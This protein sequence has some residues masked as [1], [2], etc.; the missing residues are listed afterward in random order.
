MSDRPQS[1][2]FEAA[3]P[4][5]RPLDLAEFLPY[6]LSVLMNLISRGL[7]RLYGERFGLT[8]PEWR[9]M[10]ALGR[11]PDLSATEVAARS[12]MDKVQVSRAVGRLIRAGR[13]D[14][15]TASG[16]RRRSVLRLTAAGTAIYARIVPLARAYEQALFGELTTAE[17]RA[18]D[19]MLTDLT[20][21]ARSLE[22]QVATAKPDSAAAKPPDSR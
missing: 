11:T 2:D 20:R 18:L 13:V 4:T 12:E 3:G 22:R 5:V 10:A 14:R 19:S 8:P 6:R 21:R 15:R 9:V 17:A 7:A 16:D 1:A